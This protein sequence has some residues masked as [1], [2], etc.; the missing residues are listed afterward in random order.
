MNVEIKEVYAAYETV[1][2]Y[3]RLG[4][5][6][7]IFTSRSGADKEAIGI[8]WWDGIGSVIAKNVIIVDGVVY[9]LESPTPVELDV[10]SEEAKAA[11]EKIK[12]SALAKLSVDERRVLGV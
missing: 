9:L 1:D 3:G 6:R 7:G 12:A 2:D 4:S 10:S 11:R 5:C 8:G